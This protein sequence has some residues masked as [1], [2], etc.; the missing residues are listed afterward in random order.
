MGEGVVSFADRSGRIYSNILTPQMRTLIEP[1]AKY[2]CSQ[3]IP[4]KTRILEYECGS[5]FAQFALSDES[6]RFENNNLAKDHTLDFEDSGGHYRL[7]LSDNFF[8]PTRILYEKST[9]C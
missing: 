2:G 3:E 1:A 9:L 7:R 6:F 8:I 5:G 4:Y